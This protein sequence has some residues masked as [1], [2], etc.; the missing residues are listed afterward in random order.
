M[1]ALSRSLANRIMRPVL[2]GNPS[3]PG[4]YSRM[5]QVGYFEGIESERGLECW[6]FQLLVVAKAPA[7]LHD[8]EGSGSLQPEQNTAAVAPESPSGSAR[9]GV[10]GADQVRRGSLGSASA[11]KLRPWK[12]KQACARPYAGIQAQRTSRCLNALPRT[13][14][15]RRQTVKSWPV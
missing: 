9:L 3:P 13:E 7:A 14:G 5:H 2:A 8:P 12:P 11:S 15:S 6:L 4:R 10:A 1:T